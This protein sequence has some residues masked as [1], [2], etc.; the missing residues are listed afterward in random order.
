MLQVLY[1]L[2]LLLMIFKKNFYRLFYLFMFQRLSPSWF[3]LCTPPIPSPLT[4]ASMSVLPHQPTHSCLTTLA[5][6]YIGELRA[7]SSIDARQDHSLLHMQPEPW[8]LPC[9]IFSWWFSLWKLWG[10]WLVDIVLP[11]GL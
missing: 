11:M 2:L 8:V 6:P 9:V 7:S 3:P 10:I 4:P 1:I 5:L